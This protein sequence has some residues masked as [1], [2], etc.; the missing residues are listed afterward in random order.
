MERTDEALAKQENDLR[1]D[2]QVV[3]TLSWL[4]DRRET[5]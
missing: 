2:L 4:Y 1:Q 5:D 3:S